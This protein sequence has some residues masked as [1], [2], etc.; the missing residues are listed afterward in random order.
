[1]WEFYYRQCILKS[2]SN[3][4]IP[5]ATHLTAIPV[6]FP[7]NS[8]NTFPTALAAPVEAGII[9]A[10]A[11]RPPLQSFEIERKDINEGW[12]LWSSIDN[13]LHVDVIHQEETLYLPFP[14][15]AGPSTTSWVAVAAWIVVISPSSIPKLSFKTFASGARQLVVQLAL[16]TTDGVPSY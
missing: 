11:L 9:F 8:G 7:F 5:L 15:F 13:V 14:P 10:K 16:D 2:P 12:I 6:S 4:K 3:T 1:M